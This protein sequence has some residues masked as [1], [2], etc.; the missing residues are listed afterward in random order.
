MNFIQWTLTCKKKD[1]TVFGFWPR[2]AANNIL[3]FCCLQSIWRKYYNTSHQI[4]KQLLIS[5]CFSF[6]NSC[7]TAGTSP[8]CVILWAAGDD[9]VRCCCFRAVSNATRMLSPDRVLFQTTCREVAAGFSSF[10]LSRGGSCD[11]CIVN[12][13]LR[14]FH[15]WLIEPLPFWTLCMFFLLQE[16]LC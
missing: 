5:E 10:C 14:S 2:N 6:A 9:T 15:Q 4:L 3:N 11:G 7:N 12:I 13:K 1:G 16:N 8:R